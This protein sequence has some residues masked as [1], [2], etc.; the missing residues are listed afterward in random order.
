M[1]TQDVRVEALL[2]IRCI[3]N[4]GE[5]FTAN[6]KRGDRGNALEVVNHRGQL[7]HLQSKLGDPLWPLH[8]IIIKTVTKNPGEQI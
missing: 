2:N 1:S 7:G 3:V 4:V 5:V 8:F 6:K